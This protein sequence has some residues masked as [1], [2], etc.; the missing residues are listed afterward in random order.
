[1]K[2]RDMCFIA[3]MA[4][5]M[6]VLAPLSI[7]IGSIPITLATL[8]VYLMG[9]LLGARNGSIA[10]GLYLLLGIIGLPVFSGGRSGLAT[11][12]G[13]T[14]GYMIGY[15]PCVIAT[16]LGIGK[17]PENKAAYPIS[18][19]IGTFLCYLLGT[20][21]FLVLNPCPLMHALQVCVL[22]FLGFDACKIVAASALAIA[23]RSRVPYFQQKG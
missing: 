16:G 2:T 19:A 1:M 12:L 13:V 11:V 9:A 6:A 23:I 10:V 15:I 4:A 21:W 3:I 18:M 17:W 5:L 14:G 7:P 20:I 8:V 22:P